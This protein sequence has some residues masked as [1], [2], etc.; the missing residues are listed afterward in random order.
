MALKKTGHIASFQELDLNLLVVFDAMLRTRSVTLAAQEAG[1]MQSSMS[2]ALKRLRTALADPLFVKTGAGMVP[3]AR[4]LE[5]AG[6]VQAALAMVRS[7]LSGAD[8]FDPATTTRSYVL[9]M[10][11]TAQLVFLPH[12]LARLR[13][14]APGARI[15]TVQ[16]EGRDARRM[17]VEGEIDVALGYQIGLDAGLRRSVLFADQ[18]VCIASRAHPDI[19]G[20]CT[21]EQLARAPHLVYRP[22][23]GSHHMVDEHISAACAAIGL[24]RRM[25]AEVTHG[26]GLPEIVEHTD[27]VAC[28]PRALAALH[29]RGQTLQVLE[30]PPEISI[31]EIEIGVY[32]HERSHRDAGQAW[33]RQL[34]LDLF[35]RKG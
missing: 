28:V 16:P 27:M 30:M 24:P 8:A 6:P 12:L 29:A 32:W 14:D 21:L 4:A 13:Q 1:M 25:V 11:D 5:L 34:L 26:L 10:S 7:A 3:T 2:G 35:G 31:P 15:V 18:Y 22:R 17:L 33:L 20:A 9:Y 19:Q 23:A